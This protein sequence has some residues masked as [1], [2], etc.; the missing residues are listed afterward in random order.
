[1][2]KY[3]IL[4]GLHYSNF[5]PRILKLKEKQILTKTFEFTDSCE[6]EIDETSCV[7]KLFG[8]SFGLFG[9]H[10]N[11]ARFGWTYNKETDLIVIW[12]Y[13]YDNGK[14][15][16]QSIGTTKIGQKCKFQIICNK[17]ND[18]ESEVTFHFNDCWAA[19]HMF[20]TQKRWL[21]TL[22]FYFGGHTSA[23]HKMHINFY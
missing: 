13:I 3:T 14:L 5:F 4:K 12:K 11:S 9:V 10:K 8:F 19:S 23:P 16:K 1:M 17:L 18:Y 21:L 6:Y 22:G 2:N 7:N 15:I 20:T